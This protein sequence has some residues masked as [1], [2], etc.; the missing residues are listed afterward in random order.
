MGDDKVLCLAPPRR[1][2]MGLSHAM[3]CIAFSCH[4]FC[5]RH[6]PLVT[7]NVTLAVPAKNAQDAPRS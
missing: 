2:R 4:A 3:V 5:L 7:L 1:K 6:V